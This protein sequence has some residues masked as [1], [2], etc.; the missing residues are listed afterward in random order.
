LN[1]IFSAREVDEF[2]LPRC[3][4]DQ[5]FDEH[6]VARVALHDDA[7]ETFSDG[8]LVFREIKLNHTRVA[9]DCP[10]LDVRQ[11]RGKRSALSSV[12]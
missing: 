5:E 7:S 12:L 4:S 10:P 2:A 3:D 9:H 8:Q 6:L 1:E 11:R